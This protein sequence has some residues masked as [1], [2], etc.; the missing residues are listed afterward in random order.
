MEMFKHAL[1]VLVISA[2]SATS[3]AAHA[4][5]NGAARY[6]PPRHVVVAPHYYPPVRPVPSA[7]RWAPVP[8]Y[9]PYRAPYAYYAPSNHGWRKVWRQERFD[10]GP[11]RGWNNHEWNHG[12]SHDSWNDHRDGH[13]H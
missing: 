8:H 1:A 13:N 7:Y 6:A 4:D 5:W 3:V 10:H 11:N 2:A 9:A 12:P